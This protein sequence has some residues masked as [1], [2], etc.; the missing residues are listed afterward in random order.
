[1][2]DPRLDVAALV[3]RYAELIDA[4]DFAGIGELLAAAE[5]SAEGAGTLARGAE[6]ITALYERTTRRYPNGTPGTRHVITN[7][8]A[9]VED[10]GRRAES[11]STFTVLQAVEGRLSLQP[12]VA[13]RY[14]H[15]FSLADGAWSITA[16]HITVELLGDTS[17]HLLFD[18]A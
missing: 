16:M 7:L 14:R 4:G 1:M 17:H 9:T 6:A 3:Y 11:R 18:L 2:S 8:V 12:I 15:A 5:L 10:S 13:G